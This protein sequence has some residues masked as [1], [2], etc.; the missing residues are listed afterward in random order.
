M[1]WRLRWLGF[2]VLV[3]AVLPAAAQ[4]N[5]GERVTT[6]KLG[7]PAPH[8]F[9]VMDPTGAYVFDADDGSMKGKV[10]TSDFTST[11]NV[12][13]ARRMIYVPGTFYTRGSYGERSDVVVF[14][15][16]D[17]LAAVA[18]VAI[19]NKIA[20]AGNGG[21]SGL[22][23]DR[24]LGVYNMT[25]AMSVSVVDVQKRVFV[26]ELSTA[27]CALV[28]PIRGNG[29]LQMCGDGTLQRV[30]LDGG[31][32]E[33]SRDR[34]R[35]FFDPES[36]PVFDYAVPSAS[37]YVLVSYDGSLFEVEADADRLEIAQAWS[38]LTDE[39]REDKWRVGGRQPIAF[40]EATATLLTLMHQGK[41]DT[42]SAD[43]TEIW[44]Y[45]RNTQ[46][47]GHRIVL[48]GP[49]AAINV[50]ADADPVLFV[51]AREPRTVWVFD[52]R[53]GRLERTITDVGFAAGYVRRF[54]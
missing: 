16:F 45:D 26:G 22:V 53:S 28:L 46:R 1:K 43:G 3:A 4:Q 17:S 54:Q 38:L 50:S 25:P 36:D 29:F 32:R 39:D 34:S 52:A 33:R 47:R 18:E 44:I 42:H 49:A 2:A 13:S 23:G 11:V 31:G 40:N 9:I 6:A 5:V 19:P 27:G 48:P 14:N 8:W 24:F 35:P 37:G 30:L 15:E 10:P 51:I 20:A 12:D 7:T 21:L 41:V